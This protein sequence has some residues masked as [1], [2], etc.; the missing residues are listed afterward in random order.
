MRNSRGIRLTVSKVLSRVIACNG[1]ACSY[2]IRN[3]MKRVTRSDKQKIRAERF[4]EI[5][6]AKISPAFT[7]KWVS[8]V[9]RVTT[10][11]SRTV[12]IIG[13]NDN[14]LYYAHYYTKIILKLCTMSYIMDID[15]YHIFIQIPIIL[16]LAADVINQNNRCRSREIGCG[17]LLFVAMC[18][19]L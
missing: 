3:C 9:R 19:I 1:G 16:C 14:V 17:I 2:R 4:S 8:I 18:G 11:K 5:T 6:K 10:C 12:I 13:I 7:V 15:N